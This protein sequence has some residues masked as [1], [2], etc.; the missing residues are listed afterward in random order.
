MEDTIVALRLLL[1]LLEGILVGCASWL[2][3]CTARRARSF[4]IRATDSSFRNSLS[5]GRR[6]EPKTTPS[7]Q[8]V[9]P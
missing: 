6:E 2:A 9:L 5:E 7:R 3:S 4:T 1:G 8:S